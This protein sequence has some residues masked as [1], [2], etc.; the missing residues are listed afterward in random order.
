MNENPWFPLKVSAPESVE[1]R[2]ADPTQPHNFFWGRNSA[3][4]YLLVLQLRDAPDEPVHLHSLRGITVEYFDA[5]KEFRLTLRNGDNLELFHSLCQDLLRSTYGQPDET[6]LIST[7]LGRLE[8]WQKLLSHGVDRLLGEMEIR[9]LI[10]ELLFLKQELIPHY[11]PA[12]VT[13]WHGPERK[14]QDFLVRHRLFEVKTYQAGA[15]P[16]LVV[17][18]PEQL[19]A[20]QNPLYLVAYSLTKVSLGGLNLPDLVDELIALLDGTEYAE[21]FESKLLAAKYIRTPEY[22][23]YR[24]EA[25]TPTMLEVRDGFPRLLQDVVPAGVE[26]LSYSIRL[27]ACMPFAIKPTWAAWASEQL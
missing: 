23:E 1:L 10:G 22:E 5:A 11:G 20:N 17:S 4:H 21:V 14:P 15:S 2:R 12:A 26:E 16:R 24:Y 6:H 19:W 13:T 27:D 9:G 7:L 8:R 25:S 18:S 3:G